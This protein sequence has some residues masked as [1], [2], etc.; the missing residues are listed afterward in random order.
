MFIWMNCQLEVLSP[1]STYNKC[2]K[3]TQYSINLLNYVITKG[4]WRRRGRRRR[5]IDDDDD[6]DDDDDGDDDNDG[7][8]RVR[9]V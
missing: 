6:N 5:N 7:Y 3:S 8:R 4:R 1:E 9:V 2:K